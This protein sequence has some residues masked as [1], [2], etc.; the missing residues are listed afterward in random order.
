M[1]TNTNLPFTT[2]RV[3]YQ[4]RQP[5]WAMLLVACVPALAVTTYVTLSATTDALPRHLPLGLFLVTAFVFLSFTSLSV[6]VTRDYVVAR[7]GIG[8][9]RK[10]V[11]LADIADV[12]VARTR[13]YEGWGIHWTRRGM[14][15]N[16]AGFDA[17]LIHLASGK[18][19]II[20]SD[21]AARLVSSIRRAID[22]RRARSA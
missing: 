17:A 12:Q 20:G 16:V 8:V 15:Y 11:A 3:L 18:S 14:L 6:I 7:F 21:D 2:P 22:E 19:V 9:V 5:G 13:W 10:T 4:H 1:Q